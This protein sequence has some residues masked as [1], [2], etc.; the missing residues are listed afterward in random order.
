MLFSS[1]TSSITEPSVPRPPTTRRDDKCSAEIHIVF[2]AVI[3]YVT[4]YSANSEREREG[5]RERAKETG[6]EGRRE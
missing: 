5:E 2:I 1:T 3:F 4:I 6:S